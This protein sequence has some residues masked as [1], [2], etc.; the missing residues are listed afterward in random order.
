MIEIN[1]REEKKK[2]MPVTLLLLGTGEGGKSTFFKQIKYL[3]KEEADLRDCQYFSNMELDTNRVFILYNIIGCMQTLLKECEKRKLPLEESNVDCAELIKMLKPYPDTDIWNAEVGESIKILWL[4]KSIQE[5]YRYRDKQYQLNDS[6]EYFFT[7]LDR[8]NKPD[9][10][11]S[12]DDVLRARTRTSGI[13]EASFQFHGWKFRLIDVGGQRN[14][15]KK[16]IH[17][18][19][20]VTALLYVASIIEYDQVLR[21]DNSTNRMVE[22]IQMFRE[23]VT[24]VYF[25][26]ACVILFLNKID[27]LPEKVKNSDI[28]ESFPDFKG[29][30]DDEKDVKTFICQQYSS[31]VQKSMPLH[32]HFTCALDTHQVRTVFESVKTVLTQK[33]LFQSGLI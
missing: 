3:Q 30:P 28:T 10:R 20:G 15:R 27:L 29:K 19:E 18:F 8:I 6:S 32:I 2:E 1:L 4:D 24:S 17:C 33:S 16:W 11:P 5:T 21:E 12:V 13:H 25:Q 7:N 14:E 23:L 26:S 9:Y 31:C 22:S